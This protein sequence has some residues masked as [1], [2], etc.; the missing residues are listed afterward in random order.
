MDCA[1]DVCVNSC[2]SKAECDPGGF[3]DAYVE[4]TKCPLNVC[5]SKHG[6]CGSTEE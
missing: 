2:Q 6:F 4:K 5:C 1:K 3:G